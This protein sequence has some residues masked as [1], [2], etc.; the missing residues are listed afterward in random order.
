MSV[1]YPAA[2]SREA[3]QRPGV[4]VI[5][6]LALFVQ[7]W[8]SRC[9]LA[10][11]GPDR[12]YDGAGYIADS[13]SLLQAS[14]IDWI[15]DS[16]MYGFYAVF[17]SAFDFPIADW[18]N[19]AIDPSVM[20]VYVVQAMVLA[21]AAAAFLWCSFTFSPGGIFER[22]TLSMLQAAML[23]SPLV[24]VWPSA[25]TTECLTLAGLLLLVSA[26]IGYD[27]RP[28]GWSLAAIGT[29]LI[30]LVLIRD[31]I[32]PFVLIF[33]TLIGVNG[34]AARVAKARAVPIGL[35]VL[36]IAAG[37]GVVRMMLF[38]PTEKY[39]Q[40]IFNV[41]QIRML[42]DP[43]RR[44]YFV[45]HGLPMSPSVAELGGK[46]SYY[47]R[48]LEL[49]DSELS[50][51]LV[52]YRNWV[53]SQGYK[54]YANFLLTHPGYIVRSF[55]SS[56]TVGETVPPALDVAF[57]IADLFSTPRPHGYNVNL[58]PYPSDLG[59][60]LLAPLGWAIALLYFIVVVVRYFSKT[61]MR[62]PAPAIEALAITAY[63][64]LFCFYHSDGYDTWRHA[65]PNLVLIYLSC[66]ASVSGMVRELL[67]LR[68]PQTVLAASP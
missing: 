17:L 67:A 19:A 2:G 15:H 43:D 18:A 5:P 27:R 52:V 14:G 42:P 23:L 62:K 58:S 50:P 61:L 36:L 24:I 53:L 21:A 6:T 45:D 63:V 49:P 1:V 13:R 28:H 8:A 31:P 3:A 59:Q 26:C 51:D 29:C 16:L 37:L 11:M 65:V 4:F 66:L 40:P 10:Q 48:V 20:K 25:L 56:P 57:S 9:I 54:T 47:K 38:L 39:R 55:F 60:F 41:I 30:M 7:Y 33:A 68:R 64:S 32:A 46:A 44:A 35:L 12:L 34:L 22:L